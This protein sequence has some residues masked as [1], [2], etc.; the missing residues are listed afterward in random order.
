MRAAGIGR[1]HEAEEDLARR[2]LGAFEPLARKSLYT[3]Q[4][5]A[6]HGALERRS[7]IAVTTG[8]G[9]G[10]S[11]CFQLPV[12]LAILA[13]SLGTQSRARWKG[14]ALSGSTWWKQDRREFS[15]KRLATRRTAAVR[16]LIMYPL[17][18]LVQDQ[19]DGLRALLNSPAAEQFYT[20]VLGGDRFFFGQ[21]SG[22]T[23]GTGKPLKDSLDDCAKALTGIE[24]T[25][26][27]PRVA[28]PSIQTLGG[29]ELITRWDMQRTPPDILITN[30]S[31]L[32]IMLLRAREQSIFDATRSWL[33]ENPANR[34]FLIVD[35]LHSY[36]GT[37]GTEISYTIR[38]FLNRLG[39][40]ADHPQL[41]VIATSASLSASDG[42]R[43]L[44]DFFGADTKATPFTIIDDDHRVK[45]K[46]SSLSTVRRLRREFA[47]LDVRGL[48]ESEIQRF[49][50][51]VAPHDGV[52]RTAGQV[53]AE[54]GLHDALL[55]AADAARK[56]HSDAQRLASRP[57]SLPD[58]ARLLFDADLSAARGFMKCVT[59][60]WACT[61]DWPAKTRMHLFIR[62]LDGVRRG[63]D[64]TRPGLG[65]PLLYD[66]SRPICAATGALNLDVHYCQECGELYYLGF[67]NSVRGTL[68][69]SNDASLDPAKRADALLLHV[70]REG[71]QYDPEDWETR[72]LNGFTGELSKATKPGTTQV[73][74]TVAPYDSEKRR[75]A[76]PSSCTACDANWSTKPFVKSPI[77]SMGTGYNKFSQVIVEQLVASLRAGSSD[78]KQSKLV[79]FSDS[80]RDAALIAADLEL[81]HYL[82]TLRALA[83]KHFAT[84]SRVDPDLVSYLG[85]LEDA[86]RTGDWSQVGTHKYRDKEPRA[87]RD[88]RDYFRAEIDPA[89]YPLEWA[90]ATSILATAKNPLVRVFGEE[91]SIAR[92]VQDDLVRLGINPAGIFEYRGQQWQEVF[93]TGSPSLSQAVLQQLE[94]ARGAFSERLAKK[95]REVITSAMGRDFESLGYGW[96]TFDR[97]HVR[98]RQLDDQTIRMLDVVLRFLVRHYKTRDEGAAGFQDGRLIGYFATWLG[99]NRLGVWSG[100]SLTELSDGVRELLTSVGVI[101]DDFRIKKEGLY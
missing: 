5:A 101:D 6:V 18:A 37:G 56:E 54:L 62:N 24:H 68:Y 48:G 64:T 35:E 30:Y 8:T 79:I 40:A 45:P 75:Y 99:Q 43:F 91:R 94:R 87:F 28:D 72:F 16:A 31:M 26:A 29:S 84:A 92:S 59:G 4:A 52:S 67:R 82:D 39:L 9:S 89:K 50:A 65:D 15:P 100:L 90:N 14:P 51:Q 23:P 97:T 66:A 77:R 42:Q 76:V 71:I 25:S 49:A 93:L 13:E 61:Q 7:H 21:Y 32:S 12:I 63:M 47:D 33:T 58:I 17:N 1:L 36:R 78:A 46:A 38:S 10:K 83:E 70:P 3:H 60:D 69:V 20:Q 22:S 27:T 74:L 44:G 55:V 88:L 98:A 73:S 2:F 57:L 34:F 81:N 85:A 41:Q 96:L 53:F 95:I 11:F 86:K 19:V 80:R